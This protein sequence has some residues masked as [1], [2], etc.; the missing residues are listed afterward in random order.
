MSELT[1][2]QKIIFEMLNSGSSIDQVARDLGVETRIV[3]AQITRLSKKVKCDVRKWYRN[4]G[5]ANQP[6]PRSSKPEV[7]EEPLSH[8]EVINEAA[9][10]TT[11]RSFEDIKAI[12]DD[13]DKRV[14]RPADSEV[15]PMVLLGIG[16]QFMRLCGGRMNAHQLIEDVYDAM[17]KLSDGNCGGP[18]VLPS[19]KPW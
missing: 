8:G 7:Y 13:L 5:E 6:A 15:H 10:S 16:I 17:H 2:Q 18:Q 3:A 9:K 14:V 12:V 4:T 1:E 11:P 19:S